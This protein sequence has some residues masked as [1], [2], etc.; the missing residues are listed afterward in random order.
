MSNKSNP[1]PLLPHLVN[2]YYY[3]TFSCHHNSRWLL[4]HFNYVILLPTLITEIMLL[5][6][7]AALV[8]I[9]VLVFNSCSSIGRSLRWKFLENPR[10]LKL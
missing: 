10:T 7:N 4:R 2:Y 3:T 9:L 6:M 1:V 5:R 8:T